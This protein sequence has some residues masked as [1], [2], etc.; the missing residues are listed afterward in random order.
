MEERRKVLFVCSANTC[1]S[2]VAEA[3]LREYGGGRYDVSS[4]GMFATSGEP[5]MQECADALSMLFGHPV[6]AYAHRSARLTAEMMQGNDIIVAVSESYASMLRS[7]FPAYAGKVTAFPGYGISDISHLSDAEMLRGV[8]RIR[9]DI[10]AM[11]HLEMP[12]P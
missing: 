6:S 8:T 10:L 1:R 5:M 3:L 7:H 12:Q 2:A 4:A 11:F 9:D